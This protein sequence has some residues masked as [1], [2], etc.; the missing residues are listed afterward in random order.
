MQDLKWHTQPASPGTSYEQLPVVCC[1]PGVVPAREWKAA[2]GED[3][4]KR[5]ETGGKKKKYIPFV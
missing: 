1:D 5:K 2:G 4:E 3:T